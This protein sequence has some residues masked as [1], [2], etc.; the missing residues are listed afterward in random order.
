MSVPL[1][2]PLFPVG[3]AL[4]QIRRKLPSGLITLSSMLVF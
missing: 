4:D 2:L 1:V 3:L